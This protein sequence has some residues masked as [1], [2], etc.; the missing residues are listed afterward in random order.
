[1]VLDERKKYQNCLYF[2]FRWSR[3][4][5]LFFILAII[6]RTDFKR[7]CLK[8]F[9]EMGKDFIRRDFIKFIQYYSHMVDRRPNYW[10]HYQTALWSL[11]WDLAERE[12]DGGREHVGLQ[13]KYQ[14][15]EPY[16]VL[17]NTGKFAL[18]MMDFLTPALFCKA[19]KCFI[20]LWVM[21]TC[22]LRLLKHRNS[23]KSISLRPHWYNLKW[24]VSLFKSFFKITSRVRCWWSELFKSVAYWA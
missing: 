17:Y 12:S 19:V 21:Y 23:F 3:F 14:K 4:Y 7:S 6:W 8:N 1:M 24:T 2:N 13:M 11:L 20:L 22:W 9:K 16:S 18:M 15:F 10:D 5:L